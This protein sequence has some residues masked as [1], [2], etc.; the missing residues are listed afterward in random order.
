LNLELLQLCDSL[1]P[2][3]GFAYSD[4]LETATSLGTVSDG[5][6]L[7]AWLAAVLDD[8]IRRL[9]GPAVWQGWRA[10]VDSDFATLVRLDEELTALRPSSSARRSSRAM[11]QRLLTTWQAL[12]PDVRLERLAVMAKEGAIGPV[13]PL[14][15]AAACASAGVTRRESVEAYAYTRLAATVSAAMRLM[16][17]GQTDAHRL[18]SRALERVPTVVDRLAA[19]SGSLESF[20]PIMDISAMT[21]Q[22]LHSR[23]FRS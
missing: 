23:L 12:H 10:V 3:G 18:L 7:N 22:Y 9:E 2:I 14:A 5:P 11:G 16:P 17:I 20:T 21:Q 15:F 4:G 1:F 6:G 19:G 8:T 13:L